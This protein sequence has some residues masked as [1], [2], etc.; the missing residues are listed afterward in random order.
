MRLPVGRACPSASTVAAGYVWV[1]DYGE[2]AV[3]RIDP[4]G[5]QIVEDRVPEHAPTAL[6]AR[7]GRVWVACYGDQSVVRID[8]RHAAASSASRSASA[9]TRSRV[10]VSAESA[11]VTSVGDDTPDARS[12]S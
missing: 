3:T 11:W 9:S 2:D 4:K 6:H 1:T 10:D 7:D 8:P 5:P 12:T